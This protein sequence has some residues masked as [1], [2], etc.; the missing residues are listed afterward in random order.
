MD[1]L[2]PSTCNCN[3][4]ASAAPAATGSR[5]HN[6]GG[7]TCGPDSPRSSAGARYP[8]SPPTY[9]TPMPWRHCPRPTRPQTQR[10]P[11][12]QWQY[13]NSRDLGSSQVPATPK[14]TNSNKEG[15]CDTSGRHLGRQTVLAINSNES[16][17]VRETKTCR[18]APPTGKQKRPLITNLL[19]CQAKKALCKLKS[20]SLLQIHWLRENPS[21]TMN[22]HSITHTHKRQISRNQT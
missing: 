18:I 11:P 8:S 14:Y 9:A 12:S 1:Y 10:A 22:N 4:P 19:N 7:N 15:S 13:C 21:N 6:T 17:Q 20:C 5:T 16:A 3:L 2:S